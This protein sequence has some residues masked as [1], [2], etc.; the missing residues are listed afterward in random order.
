MDRIRKEQFIQKVSDLLK[1]RGIVADERLVAVLVN[2]MDRMMY[3]AVN[4]KVSYDD[5]MEIKRKYNSEGGW[6]LQQLATRYGVSINTISSIV[7]G[8][9][10]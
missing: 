7:I 8:K 5:C 6:T 2:E 9:Y 3:D 10:W 4:R 1:S